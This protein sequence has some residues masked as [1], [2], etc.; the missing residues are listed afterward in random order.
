MVLSVFTLVV[1]APISGLRHAA[2]LDAENAPARGGAGTRA[3][4][5]DSP[6]IPRDG[7][8]ALL[9][10]DETFLHSRLELAKRATV[11]LAV[12]LVDSTAS[13]E[14]RGVPVR[15]C[16]IAR[17]EI[18][19]AI[20]LERN[21][22]EFL[23]ALSKPLTITFEMATLPKEPIRVERA[24]RDS[25]EAAKAAARPFEPETADVYYALDLDGVLTLVIRQLEEPSLQGMRHI[26]GL[27]IKRYVDQAAEA[28]FALAHLDAPRH[29][30]EIEIMLS[31]DDARAIYR[32]LS[33][34][35]GCALRL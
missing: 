18:G 19:R 12:D 15:T 8:P 3:E 20:D 9:R 13:I 5:I 11:N 24:P 14:I 7:T 4:R 30:R 22:S 35:A 25:V 16:T 34:D 2:G 26:T 10:L 31:R 1:V 32:A 27:R 33:A 17:F 28:L 21:R 23:A 29:E 6:P